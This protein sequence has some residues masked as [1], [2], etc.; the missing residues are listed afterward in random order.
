MWINHAYFYS[1]RS[2]KSPSKFTETQ[3]EGTAHTG[4]PTSDSYASALPRQSHRFKEW[5]HHTGTSEFSGQ[6]CKKQTKTP[7]VEI[8]ESCIK[9]STSKKSEIWQTENGKTVFYDCL[10]DLSGLR[11]RREGYIWTEHGELEHGRLWQGLLILSLVLEKSKWV[12]KFLWTA[13]SR[14][15][16]GEIP[17]AKQFINEHENYIIALRVIVLHTSQLLI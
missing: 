3:N 17:L 8:E 1:M 12:Q 11:D 9:E 16:M 15:D 6:N 7:R 4:I 2:Q 5:K 13:Q 14:Y 10:L